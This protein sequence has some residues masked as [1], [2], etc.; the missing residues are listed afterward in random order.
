MNPYLGFVRLFCNRDKNQHRMDSTNENIVS[1]KE[2]HG[3]DSKF[4]DK[5]DSVQ[6]IT[7]KFQWNRRIL[8]KQSPKYTERKRWDFVGVNLVTSYACM[9]TTL[10]TPYE[11]I[12]VTFFLW[13]Y[14][15]SLVNH[16]SSTLTTRESTTSIP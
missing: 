2:L 13:V 7:E 11:I 6:I 12:L 16:D 15:K 8:F 3:A 10:F 9:S 1:Y 5:E 4:P 14:I